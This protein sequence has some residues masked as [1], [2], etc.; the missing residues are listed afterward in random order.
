MWLA[1][2]TRMKHAC[3]TLQVA[4][5]IKFSQQQTS[6]N[7]QKVKIT[8]E[9]AVSTFL[10]KKILIPV[11]KPVCNSR[12]NLIAFLIQCNGASINCLH[13]WLW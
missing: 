9:K 7:L 2:V 8:E 4:V 11:C 10:L 13:L 6:V 5:E 3:P 1:T 12:P